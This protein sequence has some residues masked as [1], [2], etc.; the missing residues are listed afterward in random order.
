MRRIKIFTALAALALFVQAAHG[1]IN[2]GVNQVGNVTAGHSAIWASPGAI[3]D[4]GAPASGTINSFALTSSGATITVTGS[5]PCAGPSC[6]FNLDLPNKV[7]GATVG[8]ASHSVTL[9]FDNQGR[10]TSIAQQLISIPFTQVT[11]SL[12]CS[13]LPAFTGDATKAAASC[14]TVVVKVN[15]VAFAAAPSVDTVPVITAS[16]VATYTA[17]PNCTAGVL[18]YS[19]STHLF[20]CGAAGAGTVTNAVIA[21]TAGDITASGTC[22]ITTSGTCTL[23]LAA[24]RKTLTTS[25]QFTTGSGTYTT[26]AGVL[27]I[28]VTMIGGGGGGSGG[29]SGTAATTGGATCWAASGAACTSPLMSAGGGLGSPN[30]PNGALGGNVTGS[31]PIVWGQT[32][33]QGN[34]APGQSTTTSAMAGGAG[35]NSI[36]GGAGVNWVGIAGGNATAN[37]G[38]GGAGGAVNAGAVLNPGA[39]GGSGAA[40][41]FIIKNPA[42]SYTYAV[43]AGGA[44]GPAGSSGF[45]GG[46]GGSGRIFVIEN[47]N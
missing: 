7:T 1:Q 18:Q 5:S 9:T 15:G 19:T 14:A 46:T 16:N 27:S 3:K 10:A 41:R 30:A 45:G 12:A 29:N 22:N 47:Y 42:A 44:G 8:D 21:G 4:G 17:I 28:D 23:D 39:G 6:A 34:G 13:Q 38:S 2:N 24:S 32:G 31:L 35:G 36:T 43:G 33:G 25:Q 20:S 37:S 40:V 26:P 11:G